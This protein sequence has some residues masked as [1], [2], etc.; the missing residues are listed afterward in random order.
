MAAGCRPV[1]A[2]SDVADGKI[3]WSVCNDKLTDVKVKV[4]VKAQPVYGEATFRKEVTLTVAA[5]SS[6]V[7]VELPLE[8]MK[9][10]LGNN[11]VLVCDISYD[12]N[13]YD[14]ATWIPNMPQDVNYQKTNLMVN[15]KRKEDS[16]EV[17]IH[18]DNWARVVTLDAEVDFED[19]YFEMVPGET[20]T[21]NWKSRIKP[22]SGQINVS[23]WNLGIP[24]SKSG[25]EIE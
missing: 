14:R 8:E 6:V 11:A 3:K 25:D 22:F 15:E 1:I 2:A 20:R 23:C 16:G 10:K 13:G 24:V 12:D 21:I 7:A 9:K 5:N 4:I 17:T 18:T 19:N